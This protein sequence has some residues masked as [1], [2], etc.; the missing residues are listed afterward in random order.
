MMRTPYR[1]AS[2]KGDVERATALETLRTEKE[3]YGDALANLGPQEVERQQQRQEAAEAWAAKES[4]L[5]EARLA[6]EAADKGPR[7]QMPP[8]NKPAENSAGG[9]AAPARPNFI[10]SVNLQPRPE[11]PRGRGH[12]EPRDAELTVCLL[13]TSPSPRD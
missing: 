3:E 11:A 2:K 4:A 8:R 10:S 12:E 7:Y 5:E 9:S 13:Y 1:Q 6:K